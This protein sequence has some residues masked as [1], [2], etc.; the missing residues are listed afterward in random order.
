MTRSEKV[1]LNLIQ[2]PFRWPRRLWAV[3]HAEC[4]VRP[5]MTVFLDSAAISIRT[6]DDC[7]RLVDWRV[8]SLSWDFCAQ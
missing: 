1:M 2:H 4:R 5:G 6:W 7:H 3:N 8:H